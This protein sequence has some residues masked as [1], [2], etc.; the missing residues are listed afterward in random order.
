MVDCFYFYKQDFTPIFLHFGVV[1][2]PLT[3]YMNTK[4]KTYAKMCTV[5]KDI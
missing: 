4:H 2:L 1:F 3:V 5:Q